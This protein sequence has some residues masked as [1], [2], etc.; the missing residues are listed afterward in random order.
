MITYS[1]S[2]ADLVNGIVQQSPSFSLRFWAPMPIHFTVSGEHLDSISRMPGSNTS[3]EYRH[4]HDLKS[5]SKYI[6]Y[7]LSGIIELRPGQ[8]E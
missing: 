3:L 1:M 5:L 4:E 2:S 8:Y 7:W 6:Y